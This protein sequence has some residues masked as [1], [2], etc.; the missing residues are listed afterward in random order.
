M[1]K[2]QDIPVQKQIPQVLIGMTEFA[3][4]ESMSKTKH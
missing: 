1:M 4:I 3:L 2:N